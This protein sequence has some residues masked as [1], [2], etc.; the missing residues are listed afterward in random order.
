MG[1]SPGAL[2]ARPRFPWP[3]CPP[4]LGAVAGPGGC[5][6]AVSPVCL[7]PLLG[8]RGGGRRGGGALVPWRR[9]PTAAGGRPGGSG[10]GGQAVS[11]GVALFPRPPPLARDPR[12]GPRWGPLLPPLL[13]RGA[14]WLGAAVRVSG[15]RLVGCGA[16]GFPSALVVSALPPTGGGARPSVA[17]Y[18]G[19]G[20]DRGPG[21]AGG[22]I[23]RHCPPTLSRVCRLGR[24]LRRR[25]CRGWGCDG[26]GFRR[27]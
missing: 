7:R 2:G 24:H 26:S 16:V 9:P 23:P 12:A 10:P 3:R 13:S 18:C 4:P 14:G 8:L 6:A 11:W 27:R 22:G 1:G 5:G 20:V 19:G 25:L 15:Q 21:F 17:P